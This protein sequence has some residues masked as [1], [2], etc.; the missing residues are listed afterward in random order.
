MLFIL[1]PAKTLDESA[2]A[3][4]TTAPRFD[5]EATALAVDLAKLPSSALRE[6]LGVSAPLAALN[7]KRY[8]EFSSG[9][10]KAAVFAFYGPAYKAL[11]AAQLPPAA[12]EWLGPRLRILC[13]LYGVLRPFDGVRPYRLEMGQ[14]TPAGKPLLAHW[15]TRIAE[16]IRADVAAL[17]PAERVVVNVASAEYAAAV[18]PHAALLGA[19]VVHVRFPGAS[20]HAKQSRGAIVAFAA[21]AG[22]TR[23]E[24]LHAFT[25]LAGELRYDASASTPDELVFVRGGGRG[26]A[27]A[28][29]G[30]TSRTKVTS[31]ATEAAGETKAGSSKKRSAVAH[32]IVAVASVA[33]S[34]TKRRRA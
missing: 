25:G 22:A 31:G 11:A 29:G 1:S 8:A 2:V 5:L 17:P 33:A 24:E 13:G 20:V 6:L 19:R 9:R 18:L 10:A 14:R 27:A 34:Q 7:A 30:A 21:R 23:V 32:A 3:V 12:K 28:G 15:G 16:A 4:P 26:A